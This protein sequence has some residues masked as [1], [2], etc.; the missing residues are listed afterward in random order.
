[1]KL[2]LWWAHIRANF[3]P[4]QKFMPKLGGECSF[5]RLWF[6]CNSTRFPT[7]FFSPH[8]PSCPS[9]SPAT[10]SPLSLEEDFGMDRCHPTK[11]IEKATCL[12]Y[13]S[14]HIFLEN[15]LNMV[16]R[17]DWKKAWN[18]H[19][20]GFKND[21]LNLRFHELEISSPWKL[22]FRQLFLDLISCWFHASL[23]WKMTIHI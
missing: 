6:W 7:L 19:E 14:W 21:C 1:M 5:M 11:E 17:C 10:S 18:Q 4:I 12:T 9:P 23:F 8:P 13:N 3:D 20:N 2:T 15:V 22:E 16:M